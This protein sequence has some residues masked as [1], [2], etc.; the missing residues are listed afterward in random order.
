MVN[1]DKKIGEI[2]ICV[3]LWKSNDDFLHD[4]FTTPFRNEFLE[5]VGG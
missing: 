1:K 3:D 4:P 5:N 2:R